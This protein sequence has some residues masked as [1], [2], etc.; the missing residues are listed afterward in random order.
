MFYHL[1]YPLHT[2]IGAFNVF[3]YITF[4]AA[5]ATITALLV[6]LLLG[7]RMIQRLRQFQIGQAIREEGPQS[8]QAKEGTPTMGGLLIITAAVLPTLL[9]ADIRNVY[10]WIAVGSTV[11][12]GAIGFADDYIKVCKRRNLGLTARSKFAAQVIVALALGVLLYVL[13][14]RGLFETTLGFPFFKEIRLELGLIFPAFVVLV[15][16]GSAN[17]V[18]LTD[19]LDGLAIGSLLI[20][21]STFAILTY[22]AGNA[23]VSDYLGITNVKGSGELTVFCGAVVGGGGGGALEGRDRRDDLAARVRLPRGSGTGAR[24]RA[25][26]RESEPRARAHRAQAPAGTR[27]AEG[28]EQG[29]PGS[30][31]QHGAR[32]GCRRAR[33]AGLPRRRPPAPL[34]GGDPRALRRLRRA[35]GPRPRRV[36]AGWR[37]RW[38]TCSTPARSRSRSA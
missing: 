10:I 11:M 7:P 26:A 30:R 22:A 21:W 14:R 20:A 32:P 16:A 33:G 13:A 4:R 6:S 18:N 36:R 8:H 38:P 17:A 5:M 34:Q 24:G 35:H 27:Q 37:F 19:G 25:A 3:R 31:D 2:W 29:R 23:I 15:L 1:L 9:W 12:F 28:L